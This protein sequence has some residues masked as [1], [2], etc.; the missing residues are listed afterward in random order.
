VY[1]TLDASVQMMKL[2]KF[3]NQLYNLVIRVC[4]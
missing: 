3:T 1:D 2:A 4:S